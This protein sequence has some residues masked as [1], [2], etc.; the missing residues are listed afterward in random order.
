MFLKRSVKEEAGYNKKKF[1][2]EEESFSE[3]PRKYF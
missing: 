1:P 3:K 2:R